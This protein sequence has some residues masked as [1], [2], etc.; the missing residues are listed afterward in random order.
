[1]S[2]GST[3]NLFRIEKSRKLLEGEKLQEF[4]KAVLENIKAGYQ[5]MVQNVEVNESELSRFV[6]LIDDNGIEPKIIGKDLFDKGFIDNIDEWT[7]ID[8]ET[9][10]KVTRLI[11]QDFISTFMVLRDKWNL[12]PYS[13]KPNEYI[14]IID[15]GDAHAI[16]CA[17]SYLL[18]QKYDKS[19]ER[20]FD[21]VY[22]GLIGENYPPY[23]LKKMPRDS[24]YQKEIEEETSGWEY[25]LQSIKS[26]IE[27]YFTAEANS[28]YKES[29]EYALS[30]LAW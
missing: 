28:D 25:F 9:G 17:C 10:C 26:V 21:N 29:E 30:Y 5:D 7:Y 24:E 23:Y 15:K 22:I 19:I 13:H 2:T 12:N 18:N 6:K 3:I 11:S 1:M 27:M 14:H 16:L 4:K 8:L 20:C